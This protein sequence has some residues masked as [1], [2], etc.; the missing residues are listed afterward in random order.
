MKRKL[1]FAGWTMALAISAAL[2]APCFAQG[3]HAN[4]AQ[5]RQDNKPPKQQ[6]PPPQRQPQGPRQ[7]QR[8]EQRQERRQ[9]QQEAQRARNGRQNSGAKRPPNA[10]TGRP[11]A[12]GVHS[13]S[14]TRFQQPEF[15]GEAEG[16]GRQPAAAKIAVC[17]AAGT[18]GA[19]AGV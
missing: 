5:N 13:A 9:Q 1:Q 15:A 18:A 14:E 7:Q 16:P 6:S 17:T 8:Q 4:G 12:V 3:T 10:N 2:A 19:R 11:A